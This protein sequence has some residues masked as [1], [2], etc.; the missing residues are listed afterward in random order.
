MFNNYLYVL[1]KKFEIKYF[2]TFSYYLLY[3]N[4]FNIIK[5]NVCFL[6][7]LL[8]KNNFTNNPGFKCFDILCQNK[9]IY[10]ISSLDLFIAKYYEGEFDLSSRNTLSWG[11]WGQHEEII[12]TS[13]CITVEKKY[14]KFL[15]VLKSYVDIGDFEKTANDL[16]KICRITFP[17]L[18]NELM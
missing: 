3:I 12:K 13:T 18:E 1:N 15:L 11:T 2:L 10:K 16:A 7:Y 5:L 17:I 8:Q 9:K 14:E 4:C 6:L